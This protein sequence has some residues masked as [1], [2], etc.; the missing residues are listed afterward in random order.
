MLG[1]GE[2]P[3]DVVRAPR[4]RTPGLGSG[5]GSGQGVYRRDRATQI[6]FIHETRAPVPRPVSHLHAAA[7]VGSG[8]V[9]EMP[10]AINTKFEITFGRTFGFV[11]SKVGTPYPPLSGPTP[12]NGKS[13]SHVFSTVTRASVFFPHINN[14]W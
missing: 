12:R 9:S 3:R 4:G 10:K 6:P 5:Q 8:S 1:R 13:V 11:N 14:V 2:T 7:A